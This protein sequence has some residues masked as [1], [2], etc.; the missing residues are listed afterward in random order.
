MTCILSFFYRK[1]RIATFNSPWTRLALQVKMHLCW[2]YNEK[3]QMSDINLALLLLFITFI[4]TLSWYFQ[5]FQKIFWTEEI[6]EFFQ[7]QEMRRN[8]VLE[9][10][11]NSTTATTTQQQQLLTPFQFTVD[12]PHHLMWCRVAKA[13]STTWARV[14]LRLFGL[15]LRP[16][17]TYHYH[18]KIFEAESVH[19]GQRSKV[20]YLEHDRDKMTSFLIIRHP[21]DRL[22]SVYRDKI[23]TKV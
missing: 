1:T 11:S 8:L 16:N 12:P 10:C 23:A 19:L 5:P 3:R 20:D 15:R 18:T 14:F 13:G 9:R 21:F 7:E 22:Y 6:E 4:L 2:I 17:D